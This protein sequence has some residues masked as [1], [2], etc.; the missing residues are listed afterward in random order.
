MIIE[1]T[2]IL[3]TATIFVF[4]ITFL[5]G[6]WLSVYKP[7]WNDEIFT[8]VENVEVYSYKEM[9]LGDFEHE[10][11][12]CPLFYVLQKAVTTV[13]QYKFP[14]K[15]H[16][17]WIINDIHS[18]IILRILPNAFMA[19][20]ICMI[21]MFFCDRF[22][23]F[24]GLLSLMVVFTTFDV[25]AFWLEA[26]PYSLWFFLS[27][28]QLICFFE[29]IADE[30]ADK[31]WFRYLAVINI[32]LAFTIVLSAIQIISLSM[33]LF[34]M[35]NRSFKKYIL[36]TVMPLLIIAYYYLNTPGTLTL[37]FPIEQPMN[38]IFTNMPKEYLY[39]IFPC[40]VFISISLINNL[41]NKQK[42]IVGF[43]CE[44]KITI[45]LIFNLFLLLAASILLIFAFQSR[46]VDP[47]RA[48]HIVHFRY[49]F[50][51]APFSVFYIIFIF[52]YLMEQLASY[53][54][55]RFNF[56]LIFFTLIVVQG[57][58]SF[59]NLKMEMIFVF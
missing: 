11:N 36:T 31:K 12:K 47:S 1:R 22:S 50:Y 33:V 27:T 19:L 3:K 10:G 48:A 2:N 46:V 38:L 24:A 30:C 45:S 9:L 32:M 53:K 8:Q 59:F 44:N 43:I 39:L 57:I 42:N 29:I 6:L 18:Q 23:I 14:F 52:Y 7:L 26:R 58:N 13:L 20:S 35:G 49:F 4:L 37:Y 25:W 51:L 21:F 56:F 41:K 15:W 54:W 34:I 17:E 5:L 16:H 55:L 28:V 40:I